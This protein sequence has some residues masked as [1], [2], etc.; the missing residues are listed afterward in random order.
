MTVKIRICIRLKTKQRNKLTITIRK[1]INNTV[2][3]ISGI[4][5]ILTATQVIIGITSI[6]IGFDDLGGIVSIQSSI[7]RLTKHNTYVKYSI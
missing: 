4:L 7:L 2:I 6:C 1:Q 5:W 3:K